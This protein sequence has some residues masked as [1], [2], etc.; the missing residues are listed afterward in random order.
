MNF[1]T[2][3]LVPQ[4]A[5]PS[6]PLGRLI[7]S[8][9]DRGNRT[10]NLHVVGALDLE[11]AQRVLE[12]GFGGGVGLA[13]ALAHEPALRLS[14]VDPSHDMVLRCRRRF[15]DVELREGGVEELPW[16]AASFDAV[17]GANVTYFWPDLPTALAELRR[18][19][20]PGGKLAFGIRPP[21]VLARLKFDVAGH[22][23]WSLARYV[24]AFEAAG[25]VEVRARRMPDDGPGAYV[26]SARGP[27]AV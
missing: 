9:L 6:G 19:L 7:A 26:L 22:R 3:V 1:L 8:A 5:Q 14:G 4:L 27:R 18:V 20:A 17:F 23:V 2:D 24:E 13:T 15:V 21:E 16:P 25:F 12:V 11:P 10:I